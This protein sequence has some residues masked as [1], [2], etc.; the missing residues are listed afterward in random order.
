MRKDEEWRQR[1]E[2]AGEEKAGVRGEEEE[3][4]R[5]RTILERRQIF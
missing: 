1:R 5:E 4:K 3:W 2:R